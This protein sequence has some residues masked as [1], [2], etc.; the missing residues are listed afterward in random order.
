MSG[1]KKTTKKLA[2]KVLPTSIYQRLAAER[3][4][5][6]QLEL[7]KDGGLLDQVN[8]YIAQPIKSYLA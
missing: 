3:S 6:W 1:F 2:Q 5:R 4:R 7:L 8:Q